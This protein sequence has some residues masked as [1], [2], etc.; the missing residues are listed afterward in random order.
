MCQIYTRPAPHSGP[1][2][3]SAIRTCVCVCVCASSL[4]LGFY[5]DIQMRFKTLGDNA[6]ERVV[7]SFGLPG[8]R[9]EEENKML[10]EQQAC[11]ASAGDSIILITISHKSDWRFLDN[12]QK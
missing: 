8:L 1:V 4:V 5:V 6:M 3:D 9:R 7:W 2:K 11:V 10:V 12:L